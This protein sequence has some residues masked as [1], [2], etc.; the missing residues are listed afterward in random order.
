MI[1][2]DAT[3][4]QSDDILSFQKL[5]DG[6]DAGNF[7]S[8]STMQDYDY[9]NDPMLLP[10]SSG[11]TGIPKGVVLTHEN[12]N[13]NMRQSV[14]AKDMTFVQMPDGDSRA[15]T[16]CVLPMFHCF[17]LLVT[18]FPTLFVSGH[19]VTLPNFDPATFLKALVEH[20]VISIFEK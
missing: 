16:V 12:I 4:H 13:C 15:T 20:K 19:I 10:F 14:Y 2:L 5:I 7:D 8:A 3:N 11:T 9:K 1:V 6:V 18:C 17:G